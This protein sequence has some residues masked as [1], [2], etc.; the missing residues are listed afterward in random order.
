M[1]FSFSCNC[2][3]DTEENIHKKTFNIAKYLVDDELIF[4]DLKIETLYNSEF[5]D[6][7][8]EV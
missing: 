6:H 8:C 7:I 2:N 5:W 3:S 1:E 4:L